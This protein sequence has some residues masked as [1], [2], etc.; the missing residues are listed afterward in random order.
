MYLTPG[1]FTA[2]INE[3]T[4]IALNIFRITGDKFFEFLNV[5][6]VTAYNV[7]LVP[8]GNR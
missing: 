3:I 5:Y 6:E 1:N 8:S 4:G 7:I 2:N